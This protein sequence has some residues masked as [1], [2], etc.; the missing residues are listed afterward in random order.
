V[1]VEVVEMVVPVEVVVRERV[2]VDVLEVGGWSL[3]CGRAGERVLVVLVELVVG[4]YYVCSPI[5]CATR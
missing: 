2:V 1:L 4:Q 5:L 3:R